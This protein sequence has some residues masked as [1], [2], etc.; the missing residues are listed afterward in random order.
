MSVGYMVISGLCASD[1][2]GMEVYF[3][4]YPDEEYDLFKGFQLKFAD[5]SLTIRTD[6][7]GYF[8]TAY[9]RTL[10]DYT[11]KWV[12]YDCYLAICGVGGVCGILW[13]LVALANAYAFWKEKWEFALKGL[14]MCLVVFAVFVGGSSYIFYKICNF[15]PTLCN[16]ENR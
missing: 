9:L 13:V 15:W 5:M 7:W 6:N 14:L 3:E 4:Q 8:R 16:E 10:E 1:K 12:D 11:S 2:K